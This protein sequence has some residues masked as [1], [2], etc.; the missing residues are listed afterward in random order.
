MSNELDRS[1]DQA[2]LGLGLGAIMLKLMGDKM[3]GSDNSKTI[4]DAMAG[5]VKVFLAHHDV[6]RDD[7]QR[8]DEEIAELRKQKESYSDANMQMLDEVDRLKAELKEAKSAQKSPKK[9][10]KKTAKKRRK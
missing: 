3:F 7:L 1:I 4:E 9:R 5:V 8:K 2:T 10:P 6:Q